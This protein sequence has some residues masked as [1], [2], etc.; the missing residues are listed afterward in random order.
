MKGHD[1]TDGFVFSSLYRSSQPMVNASTEFLLRASSTSADNMSP[2]AG[3]YILPDIMMNSQGDKIPEP[4]HRLE[5]SYVEHINA[6]HANDWVAA[7]VQYPDAYL[8]MEGC[9]LTSKR[10]W[11]I[12]FSSNTSCRRYST[13]SYGG[14]NKRLRVNA[15]CCPP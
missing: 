3:L 11:H 6:E 15:S 8:A 12:R 14:V 2:G 13:S 1:R 5:R 9:S 10:F 4:P 7:K